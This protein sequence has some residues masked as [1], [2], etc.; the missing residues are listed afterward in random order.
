VAAPAVKAMTVALVGTAAALEDAVARAA[1]LAGPAVMAA[2]RE[3][4]D[5]GVVMEE[6]AQG[7]PRSPS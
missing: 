3:K 4:A 1:V 5:L 2:E 7:A 6:V